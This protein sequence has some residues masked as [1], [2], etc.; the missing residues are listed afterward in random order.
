MKKPFGLIF[1]FFLFSACVPAKKY[2]E[3]K[4][5]YER[6]QDDVSKYKSESIDNGNKVLELGVELEVLKEQVA[7][8]VTDSVRLAHE[9]AMLNVECDKIRMANESMERKYEELLASGTEKNAQLVNNLEQMKI[10]LQRKEDRLNELEE[11]LNARERALA[12]KE[13]RIS[14]LE[15][16]IASKDEVVQALKSKIAAALLGFA[17]KGITVFEKDGKIYVSMEAEL[18]F[19]S[20]KTDVN[21]DGKTA[22]I[23]LAKVLEDQKDI[24]ILVEGHTDTDV[25][26]ASSSPKDNWE[27]S[28]LRSTSVV[29]IM[30]AN[31]QMDPKMVSASGRSEFYPVDPAD[32]AKNRRIEVIITPDLS[33]LFELIEKDS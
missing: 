22:I 21:P 33:A 26:K 15:G 9:F 30:L 1:V 25:M 31:S 23:N 11:E 24:D 14:E 16:I 8:L 19:P 18:L 7:A 29:K 20:G 12:E 2:K 17:D 5:N 6:C 28:V 13:N 3:L 27:L 32:K 4:A 10:E